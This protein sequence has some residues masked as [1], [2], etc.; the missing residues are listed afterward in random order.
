[1]PGRGWLEFE[2]SPLDDGK[3][4]RIRQTA[5]FDPRGLLGRAYWYAIL[6]LHE[7]IFRGMLARIAQQAERGGQPPPS[8]PQPRA[9]R[10]AAALA[11]RRP[12][13]DRSR[14]RSW[15]LL[16]MSMAVMTTP[17]DGQQPGPVRTVDG[18][19]LDRYLGDWY[20][21]ARFPNRFQRS[22]A[23]DVRATYAKRPDGRIDVVNRCRTAENEAMEAH[24]VARL[25]DSQTSAKLKVRFAP[26]VLSFLPFVWGDYWIL[27]LAEDYSWAVVGSPDRAYLWILAR[28]PALDAERSASALAAARANA[29]DVDRLVRTRHTAPGS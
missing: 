18:V 13:R 4:S 1:M 10:R 3:R 14:V 5:T 25:V 24:G 22:C 9:P 8:P 17:V 26:S 23:G 7:L 16:L 2:V 20:E 28:S 15:T 19:N 21:I 27:G 11:P 29:F 6:P 12:R